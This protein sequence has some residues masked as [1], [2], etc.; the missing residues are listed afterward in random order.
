MK[1]C[2]QAMAIA[3]LV[4]FT[5]IGAT[6]AVEID[7]SSSVMESIDSQ[8]M[9]IKNVRT[10]GDT[11]QVKWSWNSQN[12]NWVLN[13]FE[14]QPWKS[15]PVMPSGGS[16]GAT[17]VW[18]TTL[19]V[20]GGSGRYSSIE[21]YDA[22]SSSWHVKAGYHVGFLLRAITV[23]KFI[24]VLG[25]SGEF[26]RYNPS[27]D[28]WE[29][30]PDAPTPEW[31]SEL[32]EI[33]GKIYVFGGKGPY[34]D[35]WEYNP[36]SGDWTGKAPMPTARYASA[37]AA[38]DNKIYVFG[39]NYGTRCNEV[40]D[41][42]TDTWETRAELPFSIWGWDVA[43]PSENQIVVVEAKNPGRSVIYEPVSNSY[44]WGEE[45]STPRENYTMGDS[46]YGH[47]V[48]AGGE[49][50]AGQNKLESY[51]PAVDTLKPILN[52]AESSFPSI[53][54]ME[55]YLQKHKKMEEDLRKLEER[56]LAN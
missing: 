23:G 16:W 11:Y 3:I 56:F 24:Y 39:G 22:A 15:H 48:V 27:T 30:L 26:W 20:I 54:T 47:V 46:L 7:I 29:T 12:N 17:A 38:V 32:A 44:A 51:K 52:Q 49:S 5:S 2:V 13:H 9:I 14:T 50:E 37:T 35:T 8:T 55:D 4:V 21:V 45:I 36:V 31:V 34:N 1:T 6:E 18:N 43:A 10:M 53:S 25:D 41:P 33:N 42:F 19:Y 40:Y 28:M